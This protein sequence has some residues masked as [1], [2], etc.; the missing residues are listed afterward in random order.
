MSD[1][2]IN[3][4]QLLSPSGTLAV[5]HSTEGPNIKL[6]TDI[7]KEAHALKVDK[8][9]NAALDSKVASE[10]KWNNKGSISTFSEELF[11]H[12]TDK[13]PNLSPHLMKLEKYQVECITGIWPYVE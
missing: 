9:V 3:K 1:T 12:N 5:I 13:I 6:M 7:Y 4:W 10:E 2:Y 8:T 11:Q